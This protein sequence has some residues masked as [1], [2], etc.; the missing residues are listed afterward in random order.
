MSSQYFLQVGVCVYSLLCGYEPFVGDS[1][2]DIIEANKLA[3]YDFDTPEWNKVSEDAKDFVK[4]AMNPLP[5]LRLTV[6]DALAHPWMELY[7][8]TINYPPKFSHA[9]QHRACAVS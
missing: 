7:G 3:V 6:H 8:G 1:I 5:Q 4:R 9:K 2:E